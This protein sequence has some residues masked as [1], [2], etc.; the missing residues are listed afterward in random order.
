[1]SET[2]DLIKGILSV[3]VT[4]VFMIFQ[5]LLLL[6]SW[7]PEKNDCH[8]GDNLLK[9]IFMDDRGR[10]RLSLSAFLRTEDIGDHIVHISRVI[11]TYTL[12]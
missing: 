9:S 1:M 3:F 2:D 12:E 11:I 10:E 8:F 6:N 4:C 7:R 5:V